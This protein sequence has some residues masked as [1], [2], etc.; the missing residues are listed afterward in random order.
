MDYVDF[1]DLDA[2]VPNVLAELAAARESEAMEAFNAWW[3]DAAERLLAIAGSGSLV[4]LRAELLDGF[5]NALLPVGLLDRFDATG[6]VARWWDSVAFDLE[7]LATRGADGVV[8]GWLT[9]A[10]AARDAGASLMD[11]AVI[12]TL[13]PD[14]LAHRETLAAEVSMLDAKIKAAEVGR[15]LDDDDTE[16]DSELAGDVLDP[17]ELRIAKARRTVAKKELR[18]ADA[19]LLDAAR[20]A[21]DDAESWAIV[22]DLLQVRLADEL[23]RRIV[24]GRQS[25]VARYQT[26]HDKYSVTLREL[27]TAR[28]AAAGK[29]DTFLAELGYA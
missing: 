5:D 19:S 29:V 15:R 9:T 6:L 1:T 8:E 26:W 10:A 22:L 16:D 24:A 11:Q 7:T 23:A 2:S 28:A 27:D 20:T 4:G 18:A 17:A 21:G 25:L 13:V 14:R 3:L 12:S